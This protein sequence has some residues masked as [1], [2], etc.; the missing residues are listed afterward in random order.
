MTAES[1][2]QLL[3]E[4]LAEAREA[5]VSENG[6]ELFRF[7]E[8]AATARYAVSGEYGK[9]LLHLWSPERNAVRRVIEAERKNEAV[10]LWVLRFGKASRCASKFFASATAE[11]FLRERWRAG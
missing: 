10:V 5:S 1:L 8:D 6:E 11:P 4:F 2:A 3:Q 7:S 9:C